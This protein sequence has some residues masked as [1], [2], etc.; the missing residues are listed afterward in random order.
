MPNSTPSTAQSHPVAYALAVL[1]G[2]AAAVAAAREAARRG[3]QVALLVPGEAEAE[4]DAS[5]D[6]ARAVRRLQARRGLPA[7]PL[8]VDEPRIDV[9]RGPVRFSRYRTVSVG[10]AEVRFGK[11]VVATGA[12]AG[13]VAVAGAEE[14]EPLRPHELDRLGAP[15]QR[16]AVL[17]SDGEACFWA[18]QLRRLG[19]EVHLIAAGPRLLEASDE[20]AAQIVAR[21]LE[22]EGV[23]VRTGCEDVS[24]DRT[25]NRRGV[26]L[27]RGERREKLL[28]DEV[29][30]CP[31][32][33]PRLAGL[34]LET[35]AV[36]YGARGISVDDRLRSSER[37][38]F[39]AGGACGPNFASPE[40][41]EATGRLAGW[42]ALA[43]VPRRLGRC[44]VPRYTPTD[45]PIV[46]LGLRPGEA[47]AAGIDVEPRRVEFRASHAAEPDEGEGY[48]ALLLEP[49]GRVVGATIAATGSEEL[50]LPLMLLM[51][52][53]LPLR[54]LGAITPC[55]SGRARLLAALAEK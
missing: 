29:L 4:P 30:V 11:A 55:R 54:I 48:L 2:G 21:R 24:L 51:S 22:T 42:N 33:R 26:L 15:P 41:E 3:P 37:H 23:R 25:G 6:F 18:Q 40:A 47:A 13:V 32:P 44:V 8:P 20:R 45:P 52:R 43:W 17:G 16:L 28:A 49:R 50:A 31:A 1:G 14:A 53:G 5:G 10:G 9:F 27:C 39:A 34:A 36:A 19:S 38:I 35:A 7:P 46:E 12:E